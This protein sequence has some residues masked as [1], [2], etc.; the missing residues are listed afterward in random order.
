AVLLADALD[1]LWRQAA[2][3]ARHV[4]GLLAARRR[5]R[6]GVRRLAA[7]GEP[8][9]DVAAPLQLGNRLLDRPAGRRLDDE[10]VDHH[11]AEQGR[12]HEQQASQDVGAHRQATA[13]AI[14]TAVRS[15]L[16]AGQAAQ[17]LLL[18]EVDP[19]R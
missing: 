6:G 15:L 8:A 10:E 14:I 16:A 17:R 4:V 18:L 3:A 11:D 9:G 1:Q 13:S 7:A 2:V 12:D 19:P 5:L